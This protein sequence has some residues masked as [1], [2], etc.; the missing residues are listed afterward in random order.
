MDAAA[1]T[2]VGGVAVAVVTYVI[3]P[4]VKDRLEKARSNDPAMGWRTAV[5]EVKNQATELTKRVTALEAENEEL[6]K[7]V[8]SL[9]EQL[10]DK[11]S[12]IAKL[13]RVVEDQSNMILA[14][15]ARNSQLAAVYRSATGQEPP[16]PDPAFAYWLRTPVV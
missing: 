4:W 8:E 16:P 5:D 9:Q 10:N 7:K 3:N 13:E 1:W 11:S 6:E 15:D 2:V 14:R 12:T